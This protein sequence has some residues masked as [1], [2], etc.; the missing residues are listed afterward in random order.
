M[1]VMLLVVVPEGVLVLV[2][3]HSVVG[4][5]HAT[6]ARPATPAQLTATMVTY[7]FL[8]AGMEHVNL[9]MA[10]TVATARTA[11]AQV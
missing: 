2:H 9:G 10:R 1:Y 11:P 3:L 7:R 6:M 5:A 4:M 8:V